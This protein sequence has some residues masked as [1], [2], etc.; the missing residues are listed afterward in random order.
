MVG[1]LRFR[2]ERKI[3]S[4]SFKADMKSA[5][6][7]DGDQ[8]AQRNMKDIGILFDGEKEVMRFQVQTVANMPGARHTDTIY[9][10]HFFIKWDVP[11]RSFKGPRSARP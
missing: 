2:I 4:Y 5:D 8:N 10:G 9:P 6:S 11:R 1:K 3:S 7:W